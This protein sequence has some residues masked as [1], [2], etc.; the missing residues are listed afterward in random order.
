MCYY[1]VCLKFFVSY[2]FWLVPLMYFDWFR[3][4][5]FCPVPRFPPDRHPG[6]LNVWLRKAD[7]KLPRVDFRLFCLWK[8]CQHGKILW[9]QITGHLVVMAAVVSSPLFHIG[10][11]RR[12]CQV[13][14]LFYSVFVCC[15]VAS[16]SFLKVKNETTFLVANLKLQSKTWASWYPLLFYSR[17]QTPKVCG[18]TA[19]WKG[20]M[21]Q[22]HTQLRGIRWHRSCQN[23]MYR[24]QRLSP[25]PTPPTTVTNLHIQ[26]DT[27]KASRTQ[28]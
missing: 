28:K 26:E 16:S 2:V 27:G 19:L 3:L 20:L 14:W 8:V 23:K 13:F 18:K 6:C 10:P 15:H 25:P 22:L 7:T 21:S 17:K 11:T 1:C 5:S 4:I 24:R 12:E 9:L